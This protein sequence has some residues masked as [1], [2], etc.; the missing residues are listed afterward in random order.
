M[1]A[2]FHFPPS[3]CSGS[4]LVYLFLQHTIRIV[5]LQVLLLFLRRTRLLFYSHSSLRWNIVTF[6]LT[7]HLVFTITHRCFRTPVMFTRMSQMLPHEFRCNPAY[8]KPSWHPNLTHL[9]VCEEA[10]GLFY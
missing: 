4:V 6:I 10:K 3:S 1:S 9:I 8:S 2:C 7:T 5:I